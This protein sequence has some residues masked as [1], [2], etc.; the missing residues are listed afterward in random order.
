MTKS[1]QTWPRMCSPGTCTTSRRRPSLS[2]SQG[3]P[4]TSPRPSTGWRRSS[5]CTWWPT[6]PRWWSHSHRLCTRHSPRSSPGRTSSHLHTA[7]SA[8]DWPSH[9]LNPVRVYPLLH[10]GSHDVPAASELV[11]GEA[12]P[13]S[14]AAE[15]SQVPEQVERTAQV[16]VPWA[17]CVQHS[18]FEG[19]VAPSAQQKPPKLTPDRHL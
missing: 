12:T 11:Q 9:D 15:A 5:L 17:Q 6:R 19:D 3:T 18:P 1:T 16:P 4:R 14:I 10:V 2:R 13:F 8:S 7:V